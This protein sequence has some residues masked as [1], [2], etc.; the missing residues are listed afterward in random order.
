MNIS[1][2]FE[3]VNVQRQNVCRQF[4]V[5]KA[6]IST[7]SV[8]AENEERCGLALYVECLGTHRKVA[9]CFISHNNPLN[10]CLKYGILN[11]VDI[12]GKTKT[13]LF[14]WINIAFHMIVKAAWSKWDVVWV[15]SDSAHSSLEWWE[16]TGL[17]GNSRERESTWLHMLFYGIYMYM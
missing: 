4:H 10:Y 7:R 2:T 14:C 3:R 15:H 12:L 9:K 16:K 1:H 8:T 17:P 13:C 5:E 11:V 6:W